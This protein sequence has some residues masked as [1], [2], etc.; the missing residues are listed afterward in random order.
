MRCSLLYGRLLVDRPASCISMDVKGWSPSP[1]SLLPWR[2]LHRPSQNI[3]HLLSFSWRSFDAIAY[4][5]QMRN[6]PILIAL[7][8]LAC[9]FLPQQWASPI[10]VHA[11][12]RYRSLKSGLSRARIRNKP[13]LTRLR[14]GSAQ[15]CTRLL[16]QRNSCALLSDKQTERASLHPL[17]APLWSSLS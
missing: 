11:L 14:G 2:L 9:L 5:W 7:W 3:A 15:L 1:C 10:L 16:V 4:K 8:R 12:I 17:C 13:S 6:R